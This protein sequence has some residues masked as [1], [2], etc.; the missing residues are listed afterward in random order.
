GV[1]AGGGEHDGDSTTELVH[2][3][4]AA[5]GASD[6][7]G[8]VGQMEDSV[9]VVAAA[10]HDDT[11]PRAR[12]LTARLL[13]SS[14]AGRVGMSRSCRPAALPRA[15][16]EAQLAF[17]LAPLGSNRQ[18]LQAFDDLALLRL[19]A[20]LGAGPELATF[21]EGELG[22]LVAYD[23]SH[24]SELVRT[25]DA[26]LQANGNKQEMGELLHLRRRSVY[27]RLDRIEE[28][29]GYSLDLPDRRARLYV[30]LRGRELLNDQSAFPTRG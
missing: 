13:E 11:H 6:W 4:R 27:Y 7:P 23:E 10:E 28:I 21:V 26:F 9:V 3:T 20:P 16:R 29:L 19:L 1:P 5:L 30:A 25:L 24:S 12:S 22:D 18:Q 15:F 8:V 17:R 2:A 14:S